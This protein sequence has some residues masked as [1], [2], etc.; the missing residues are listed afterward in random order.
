MVFLS[1]EKLSSGNLQRKLHRQVR[2]QKQLL[3]SKKTICFHLQGLSLNSLLKIMYT[4]VCIL[5][6]INLTTLNLCLQSNFRITAEHH[7]YIKKSLFEKECQDPVLELTQCFQ[8]PEQK[9]PVSEGFT[10]KS[11]NPF[12]VLTSAKQSKTKQHNLLQEGK[13]RKEKKSE[14]GLRNIF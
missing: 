11:V 7:S 10:L 13:K 2:A 4:V 8:I 1:G 12:A 6:Q 5:E 3:I 14:D 9:S